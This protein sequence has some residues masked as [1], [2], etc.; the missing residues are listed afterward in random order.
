MKP[1]EA[2]ACLER[3]ASRGSRLGLERVTQLS[4]ILEQPQEKI[5]VIHIAGTNGKG[6]VS[7]MI[8]AVL[9]AAGY[10]TGCFCSPA[11]TDIRDSFMINGEVISEET[12]C[13]VI[14][15][16][17]S[18]AEQMS[19]KPT[20]FEIIA[21]SAYC[22]FFDSGC[23]IAVIECGMGGDLDATNIVSAPLLSVITN[24]ALDHTAFLGSTAEEIAFHKAGIIKK[25]RPVVF[26]GEDGETLRVIEKRAKA[27]DSPLRTTD[28]S[29]LKVISQDTDKT[30]LEYKQSG[31]LTVSLSG[32]YQAVNA[33]TA[34]E[35]LDILKEEGLDISREMTAEGLLNVRHRGRFETLLTEPL[36]IFDG[37]HNPDGLRE[38]VKSIKRY[39]DTPVIVLMGV[40]ADKEYKLYPEMLKDCTYS[41]F[42]VRPDNARA[43]DPKILADVFS[44]HGIP[45]AAYEDISQALNDAIALAKQKKL[46]LMIIGSLYM[47]KQIRELTDKKT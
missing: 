39:F 27:L 44:E 46:P 40:M 41:L 36:T 24:A 10:K 34:L 22:C 13:R 33:A 6:S 19:D 31:E 35:A 43:L 23:D 29:A 4:Q 32:T 2:Y 7:A 1:E 3:A 45:A 47:Y 18:A 14:E 5:P 30:V 9:T 8:C 38:A 25:G 28:R 15:K 20:Q 11:L 21:V 16:V 17:S 26:G 12:F 42:A 37:A